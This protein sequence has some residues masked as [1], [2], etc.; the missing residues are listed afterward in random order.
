MG[1]HNIPGPRAGPCT[2]LLSCRSRI[3]G[4]WWLLSVG[5]G[6]YEATVQRKIIGFHQD[7]AQEWVADLACGHQ[8]HVRHAPPWFNHPWV[9]SPEGRRSRLGST[10]DCKHCDHHAQASARGRSSSLLPWQSHREPPAPHTSTPRVAWRF[11]TSTDHKAACLRKVVKKLALV[12]LLSYSC[13]L[14]TSPSPRDR[15]KSRMPSS[16]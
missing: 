11:C 3:V 15:Q 7:A 4:R 13:L 9:V 14:Y 1:S 8:Q 16:A 6:A 5:L 10:L 12:M 2:P